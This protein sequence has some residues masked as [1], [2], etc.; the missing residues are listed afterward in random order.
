MAAIK[1]P[2][3]LGSIIRKNTE[4]KRSFAPAQSVN[5]SARPEKPPFHLGIWAWLSEGEGC[6]SYQQI[7][8]QRPKVKEKQKSLFSSQ[9]P[10]ASPTEVQIMKVTLFYPN[11]VTGIASLILIPRSK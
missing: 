5:A 6:F 3:C 7:D 8:P 9:G 2:T 1:I 11:S 10:D 4:Q